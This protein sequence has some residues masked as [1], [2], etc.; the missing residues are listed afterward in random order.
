MIKIGQLNTL[1]IIKEVPFG[2]FLDAGE[3][4]NVLLPKRYLPE[5]AKLGDEVEVIVYF[6]T[7]DDLIAT[8][9]KPIAYVGDFAMLKVVGICGVGAFADMGLV[10]D[11]L[12]PFNE[13]RGRLEEGNTYLTRIYIDKVT[14]RLV[15]STKINKFLDKTPANYKAGE[16][17][18]L[19]AAER[20]DMGMKV[21]VNNEHLGLIF[22]TE[23]IGN[24]SPGKRLK[25][26]IKN[27]RPD[28]K[29]DIT[30]QRPGQGKVDDLSVKI[31]DA[32]ARCDGFLPLSDKSSPDAIFSE[33]RTSKAT[34][35]RTIGGLYKQGK[36]TIAKDGITL[37]K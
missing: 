16:E 11:L 2:V 36:I 28:G 5:G 9:E 24:L 8:T 37:V 31:L 19:I 10:K 26:Y 20:T 25:G 18:Q 1:P 13:H 4:G 15:G 17:V 33:F 12:I 35:K 22:K 6:D 32:L 14:G 7:E 29:L 30:L 21:I 27:I 34:F 3:F 23:I